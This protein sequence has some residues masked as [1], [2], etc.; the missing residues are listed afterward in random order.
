M[1]TVKLNNG[2]TF[3][4]SSISETVNL[5]NAVSR[6]LIIQ[7]D[8]N[9]KELSYYETLLNADNALE[10][11]EASNAFG[12]LTFNGFTNIRSLERSLG[13]SGIKIRIGLS[14]PTVAD[15]NENE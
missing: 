7:I 1:I 12:T 9:L 13:N 4:A 15:L 2:T 10:S 5:K 3:E 6:Q 14:I 11:I 8:E